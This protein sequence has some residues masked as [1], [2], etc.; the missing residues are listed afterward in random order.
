MADEIGRT[1]VYEVMYGAASTLHHVNALGLLGHEFDWTPEALRIAHGSLLQ[2]LVS[3]YNVSDLNQF[4]S[5]LSALT[6]NFQDVWN[7]YASER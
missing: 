1:D 6:K 4:G 3:L 2:T 5:R 7:Q